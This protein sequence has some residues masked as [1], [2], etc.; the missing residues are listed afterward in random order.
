MKKIYINEEWCLGCHLC[1]Y[2]CAY[3]NLNT[4]APIEQALM[5]KKIHPKIRV[6]EGGGTCFALSCRQCADPIC[7]KSCISGALSVTDGLI[8]IRRDKCVG[9]ETCVLVCPFGAISPTEEGPM[10]KCELCLK[11]RCGEPACVK[12]CPNRAIVYEERG[13]RV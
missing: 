2:A 11:N 4:G 9:C 1:E 13:S 7:V 5:G 8:S 10:Q 6:E 3:A 12:A